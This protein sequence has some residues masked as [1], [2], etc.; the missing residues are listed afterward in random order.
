MGLT[1]D[2]FRVW[3]VQNHPTRRKMD[4]QKE[5]GLSPQ[6]SAKVWEDRF[7]VRSD[8]IERICATYRLQPGQVIAFHPEK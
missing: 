8:V 6:T 3:F 7:P 1:F 2:P 5:T 4:F